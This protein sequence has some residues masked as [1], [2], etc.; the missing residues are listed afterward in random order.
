MNKKIIS[1]LFQLSND[2]IVSK[3]FQNKYKIGTSFQRTRKLSFSTLIYF[4]LQSTHKSISINYANL[5]DSYK[6]GSL[7]V[8]SRQAISKARQ[9][10]SPSA[11]FELYKLSVDYYYNSKNITKTWNS[12]HIFAVDGSTIQIPESQENYLYF[13]GNPNNTGIESPL[14]TVSALYDVM[15]DI[16]I[17]VSLNKYRYNERIAAK[18]H[19]EHLPNV[20]KSI[21]VFDRGYPSEELFRFL[22]S[23]KIKFVMRVPKTFKKAIS[24][25]KDSLFMYENKTTNTLSLRRLNLNISENLVEYLVTNISSDE[26]SYDKFKELYHLRWGVESKY[27]E[28]KNRFEIESFSG[29]KP[30]IIQQDFFAAV[31]LSNIA[32][33]L[34][35]CSD[36]QINVNSKN[37]HQYQ[38][39]RSYIIN[40]IKNAI[41][42]LLTTSRKNS[43]KII[44]TIIDTASVT[45]SIIRPNRKFGR[46]RKHTRRRYYTHM[47]NCI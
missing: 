24:E 1:N 34:K 6:S 9:N 25:S 5:S 40:R 19:M 2:L 37:I 42:M 10:I 11:F 47:K 39:N 4:V 36:S 35:Q 44:T 22:D 3:D 32:S 46:F 12:Y 16:L 15:N 41:L 33:M 21:V 27:R 23:R 38:S 14:A 43:L 45:L 7:P 17:D 31:Y 20:Q 28:L 29:I 8:V 18:E 26:L 13:G 30:V